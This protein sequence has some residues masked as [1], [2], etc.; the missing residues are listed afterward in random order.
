VA[1][2]IFESL[3]QQLHKDAGDYFSFAIEPISSDVNLGASI[4]FRVTSRVAGRVFER[5]HVDI[6]QGDVIVG[7]IDY[8][9]P[10]QMLSFAEITSAPFPCYPVTQHIAEKLH[11][12]DIISVKTGILKDYTEQIDVVEWNHSAMAENSI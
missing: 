12:L 11:A 4:R 10:P 3:V 1:T 8:L 6:G 5:F 2:R 7:P 9:S